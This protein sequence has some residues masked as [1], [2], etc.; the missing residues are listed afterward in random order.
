[1]HEC[2]PKH[3]RIGTA[4]MKYYKETEEGNK[5]GVSMEMTKAGTKLRKRSYYE[6]VNI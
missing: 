5:R 4:R 2:F 6:E 1:M 3:S